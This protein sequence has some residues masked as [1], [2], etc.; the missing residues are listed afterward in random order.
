MLEFKPTRRSFKKRESEEGGGVGSALP[1]GEAGAARMPR[2]QGSNPSAPGSVEEQPE[3]AASVVEEGAVR[4]E[5][6]IKVLVIGDLIDELAFLD[7]PASPFTVIQGSSP[8]GIVKALTESSPALLIC[9][10]EFKGRS[11]VEVLE[12]IANM[13]LSKSTTIV[14]CASELPSKERIKFKMLQIENLIEPPQGSDTQGFM[15]KLKAFLPYS[16]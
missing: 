15:E 1:S 16:P 12:K 10:V 5:D 9:G 3:N 2:P 8:V 6:K 14:V 11:M 4:N 7:T 13:G